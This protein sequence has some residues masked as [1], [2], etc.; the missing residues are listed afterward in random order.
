[1]SEEVVLFQ[2]MLRN[3]DTDTTS[4][5]ADIPNESLRVD[6][7]CNVKPWSIEG[8]DLLFEFE[9]VRIV[10]HELAPGG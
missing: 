7:E 9:H 8:W 1:M 2:G 6:I 4:R 10:Q 5:H 3:W